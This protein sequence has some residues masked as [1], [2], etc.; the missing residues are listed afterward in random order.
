MRTSHTHAAGVLRKRSRCQTP[1][2]R[3]TT[4]EEFQSFV[5]HPA[6]RADLARVPSEVQP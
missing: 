3:G 2:V 5:P 4:L 6:L 1:R